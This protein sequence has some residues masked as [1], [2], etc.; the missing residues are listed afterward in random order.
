M[1]P[2][3]PNPRVAVPAHRRSMIRRTVGITAALLVVGGSPLVAVALA[4]DDAVTTAAIAPKSVTVDESQ[5]PE[6]PAASRSL[7]RNAPVELLA[8]PPTKLELAVAVLADSYGWN[9]FSPRVAE[10]QELLGVTADGWYGRVTRNAHQ[11]R[12]EAASMSLD[13]LPELPT[14]PTVVVIDGPSSSAWAALRDCE[15]GGDYSITNPSGK[16]R[17]AYQFDRSTWNSVAERHAPALAGVDPAV[18][19]PA[20]QDAMAL[21]LYSERG[22]R[23]WPSCGRH[24]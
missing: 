1:T 15:S 7:R 16:Y 12:L 20:E 13:A 2:R 5:A 6:A 14:I 11:A 3:T 23:P 19:T 4:A 8:E 18:A 9:E 21:A 24:L 22:A 10:L 17:G